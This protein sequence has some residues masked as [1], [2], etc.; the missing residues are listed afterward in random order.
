MAQAFAPQL[1]KEAL[2]QTVRQG[3]QT[4]IGKEWAVPLFTLT[5]GL[6]ASL[7]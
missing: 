1:V 7:P 5:L 6:I 3:I 4:G 2:D